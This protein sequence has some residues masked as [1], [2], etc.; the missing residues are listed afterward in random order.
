MTSGGIVAVGDSIINADKSWGYWLALATGWELRRL[1]VGG[2]TSRH[3]LAQLEAVEGRY[4]LGLVTVGT[5]DV[6]FDWE[7]GQFEANLKTILAALT[8]ACDRVLVQTVPLALSRFPGGGSVIR[9]RVEAANA[10]LADVAAAQ[11]VM[12]VD[13]SDLRGHKLMSVDRV[14]PSLLGQTTLADKAA[15]VLGLPVVPSSLHDGTHRFDPVSHVRGTVMLTVRAIVK[16]VIRYQ[17]PA[18]RY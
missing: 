7:P 12:V 14:H 13:G 5:N 18:I 2:A 1:S 6:L 16:R 4:A 8:G 10:I 3:A 15:E 17:P 9:R 11:C